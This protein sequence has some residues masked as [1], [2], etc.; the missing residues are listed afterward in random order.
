M[1][2]SLASPTLHYSSVLTQTTVKDENISTGYQTED[3]CN[4]SGVFDSYDQN[5]EVPDVDGPF[6]L[7]RQSHHGVPEVDAGVS[8]TVSSGVDLH[9][10]SEAVSSEPA[11]SDEAPSTQTSSSSRTDSLIRD[12]GFTRSPSSDSLSSDSGVVDI[13]DVPTFESSPVNSQMGRILR[14]ERLVPDVSL[15]E[16]DSSDDERVPRSCFDDI[17]HVVPTGFIEE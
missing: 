1:E 9:L 8:F 11:S 6:H 2:T 3:E 7:R 16:S 4:I 13:R 17:D 12:I 10:Y 5:D 14:R 15:F